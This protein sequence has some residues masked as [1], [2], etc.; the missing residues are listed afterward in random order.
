LCTNLVVA[1]KEVKKATR[2][3]KGK[4][5][6]EKSDRRE[7]ISF[8]VGR[9]FSRLRLMFIDYRL[10]LQLDFPQVIFRK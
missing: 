2:K 9:F 3:R 4:K 8:H 10:R 1:E 7:T 6:K 5:K